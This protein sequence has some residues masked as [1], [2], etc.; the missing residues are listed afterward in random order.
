MNFE[1]R[2]QFEFS[3]SFCS[4]NNDD[5]NNNNSNNTIRLAGKLLASREHKSSL[6]VRI[7]LTVQSLLAKSQQLE[8]TTTTATSRRVVSKLRYSKQVSAGNSIQR[9]QGRATS[10]TKRAP[11]LAHRRTELHDNDLL[12]DTNSNTRGEQKQYQLDEGLCEQHMHNRRLSV[13]PFNCSVDEE[14]ELEV[15]NDDYNYEELD[16]NQIQH[17]L[18]PD[19][20]T[21]RVGSAATIASTE[22][23]NYIRMA[24]VRPISPQYQHTLDCAISL[25]KELASKNMADS[26]DS[27]PKTPNSPDKK[28][29]NFKLKHYGKSFSE[30]SANIRD[31]E[32][33]IS[34]GARQAYKSLVE[35]GPYNQSYEHQQ[36]Q[37]HQNQHHHSGYHDDFTPSPASAAASSRHFKHM[38]ISTFSV[39]KSFF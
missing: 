39:K 36:H 35:R 10:G 17:Q 11:A 33:S 12:L 20:P 4:D 15:C 9:H 26:G 25:A 28:R 2:I 3:L 14:D 18:G 7:S 16:Q 29:F 5:N 8:Q 31:I 27:S 22:T 23:L 38:G 1:V 34:D 24:T 30:A 32:S 13:A 19:Q 6:L 21:A 37:H